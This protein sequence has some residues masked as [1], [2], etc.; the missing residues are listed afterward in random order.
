MD[1]SMLNEQ[2]QQAVMHG[3]NPCL[4]LAGAGSGKTRVLLTFSINHVIMIM[5]QYH[6]TAFFISG[7]IQKAFQQEYEPVSYCFNLLY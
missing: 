2:Q 6:E 7:K 1:L 3:E 5:K 4:V